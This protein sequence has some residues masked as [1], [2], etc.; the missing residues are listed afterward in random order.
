MLPLVGDLILEDLGMNH[1]DVTK[2]IEDVS[3]IF[4]FAA[5]LKLESNVKDAVMQNTV[6]TKTLLDIALKMKKLDVINFFFLK[7]NYNFV[8]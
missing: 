3:F 8:L 7:N 2:L 5:T 1:D 4:H 6:G